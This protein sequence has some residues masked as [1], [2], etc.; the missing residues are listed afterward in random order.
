MERE[1]TRS[2]SGTGLRA[3]P[4]PELLGDPGREA[5]EVLRKV[6]PCRE[7][8][9]FTEK[10]GCGSVGLARGAVVISIGYGKQIDCNSSE[11]SRL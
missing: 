2:N 1:Q 3:P 4:T 11:L 9:V 8:K 7:G 6:E 5:T 10:K